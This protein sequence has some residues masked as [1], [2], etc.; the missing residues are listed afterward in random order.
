MPFGARVR[1]SSAAYLWL[2]S[3]SSDHSRSPP[4]EGWCRWEEAVS[5]RCW[6]C[7]CFD[8]ARSSRPS[9]SLEELWAGSPPATA[10]KVVQLYVSRLRKSLGDG[11]LLTRAPGY[12][13]RL[14]PENLD[15]HRFERLF[16]DGREALARGSAERA[17]TA[18]REALSLWRGSALADFLYEPFAQGEIARLEDLRLACLEERID[19]ELALGSHAELTG[20]LE[21]LVGAHPLRERPRGQLMLALYRSG[22]QAE[23]LA[24]YQAARQA[25]VDELGI[26]PGPSLQRLEK[27]ILNLE[28]ELDRPAVMSGAVTVPT[29]EA[30][31]Q[32]GPAR[33]FDAVPERKLATVVFA[34]LV[35]STQLGE[36][37]PERTRVM[38]ER[39]YDAMATEIEAAGGTVEKFAGDAVMAIF[40]APA[41]HEDHAVRALHAT[42][43]MRD[44]LGELFGTRSHSHR[45]EH[46]R[47]DRRHGRG[48]EARSQP[49]TRSMSPRGSNRRR[50]RAR[51]SSGSARSPPRV[52]RSISTSPRLSRRKAS[53]AALRA[54]GS[55]E[56]FRSEAPGAVGGLPHAFVGRADE[57]ELLRAAY[58]GRRGDRDRIC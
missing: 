10:A 42:L 5:A 38:L 4:R 6:R 56:H 46:G 55:S 25:L 54:G 20:E 31:F 9:R 22:R 24:A 43:A 35:G 41:A 37:D 40:G 12:V 23:A 47:G 30:R 14:D 27:A 1:A 13:L 32:P 28:P 39:F 3:A 57:L 8:S 48:R 16:E 21:A 44:R 53:P 11:L 51:S 26:E 36:G 50:H 34:D 15:A 17:A 2:S 33:V 19:A 58:R 18:L 52:V 49:A 45:S 7:C 29:G